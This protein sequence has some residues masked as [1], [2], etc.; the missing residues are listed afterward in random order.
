[1]NS[2]IYYDRSHKLCTFQPS[3]ILGDLCFF[4]SAETVASRRKAMN[5]RSSELCFVVV[6]TLIDGRVV[7]GGF[8]LLCFASVGNKSPTTVLYWL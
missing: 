6:V 7:S 5:D 4:F 3:A 8:I 1:M 2:E